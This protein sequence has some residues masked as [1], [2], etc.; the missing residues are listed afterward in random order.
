VIVTATAVRML[1]NFL[2][3]NPITALVLSAVINGLLAPPIL[4]L[5]MLASG[6]RAVMGERTN[7]RL[8]AAVGW[9][10]TIVMGLAAI[11]LIVTTIL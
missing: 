7:G 11:A 6:N 4:G 9:I 10:T 5:V 2:G 3:I 8:V 1:I